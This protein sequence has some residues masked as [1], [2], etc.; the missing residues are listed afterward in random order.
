MTE[1]LATLQSIQAP[2]GHPGLPRLLAGLSSP[3]QVLTASDHERIHGPL[4]PRSGS[5]LIE[6]VDRSGLR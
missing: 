5:E 2:S 6:M 4:P 3:G 1:Q